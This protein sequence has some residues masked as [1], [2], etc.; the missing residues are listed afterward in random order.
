MD[1]EVSG[2]IDNPG[3]ATVGTPNW[4]GGNHAGKGGNILYVDGSVAWVNTRDYTTNAL[5]GWGYVAG[6]LKAR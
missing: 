4:F 3:A 1:T 2:R 5:G 6:D